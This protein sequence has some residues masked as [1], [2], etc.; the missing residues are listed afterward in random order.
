M[1]IFFSIV[2]LGFIKNM[3][4]DN[5]YF[6]SRNPAFKMQSTHYSHKHFFFSQISGNKTSKT[7]G[8]CITP[9]CVFLTNL[10]KIETLE[11]HNS[12]PRWSSWTAHQQKREEDIQL[13]NRAVGS[14]GQLCSCREC[15]TEVQH[16]VTGRHVLFLCFQLEKSTVCTPKYCLLTHFFSAILEKIYA[17]N[18]KCQRRTNHLWEQGCHNSCR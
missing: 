11:S 5:L 15:P 13:L 17:S 16:G 6:F 18:T 1:W 10:G 3:F 7:F 8:I 9:N 4:P 2:C 12:L 14:G